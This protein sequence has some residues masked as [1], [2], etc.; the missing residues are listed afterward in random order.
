M[1]LVT[2]SAIEV[3]EQGVLIGGW[4]DQ[5][6]AVN[7]EA[8]DVS[9]L[10]RS[11]KRELVENTALAILSLDR[12]FTG[13]YP[14]GRYPSID[15]YSLP[16]EGV[17]ESGPAKFVIAAC[18][19]TTGVAEHTRYLK[20][21]VLRMHEIAYFAIGVEL[22][23]GT[24]KAMASNQDI[25]VFAETLEPIVYAVKP[26]VRGDQVYIGETAILRADNPR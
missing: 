6:A 22:E 19:D 15:S 2:H 25:D 4:L 16:I 18:L 1:S 13:I 7:N 26:Q 3:N 9:P 17:Y 23:D 11:H 14:G 24:K 21:R 8:I 20:R 12:Q 10:T 5:V